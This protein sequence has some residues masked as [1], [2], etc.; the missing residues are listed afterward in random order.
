M[1]AVSI[2]PWVGALLLIVTPP[3][4]GL[5]DGVTVSLAWALPLEKALP[6]PLSA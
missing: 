3:V 6:L 4:G 2:S 1:F 5:F